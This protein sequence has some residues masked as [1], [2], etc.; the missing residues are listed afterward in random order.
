MKIES[1]IEVD[2][3]ISVISNERRRYVM[4]AFA[5]HDRLSKSEIADHVT[6]MQYGD[7]Y[8]SGNRSS[9]YISLSQTHIPT[10]LDLCVLKENDVLTKGKHFEN[11]Y[12]ALSYLRKTT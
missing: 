1:K 10:M 3:L 5:E 8:T 9:V 2:T 7:K 6:R 11:T 4:D 12:K